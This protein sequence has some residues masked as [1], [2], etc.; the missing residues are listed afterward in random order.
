MGASVVAS[1][2]V[3][4]TFPVSLFAVIGEGAVGVVVVVVVVVIGLE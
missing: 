2:V 3:V 1:V 4:V